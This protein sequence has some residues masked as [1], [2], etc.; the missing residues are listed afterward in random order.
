MRALRNG[1]DL[2]ALALLGLA[3][4]DLCER[5]LEAAG[6]S[7]TG[8]LLQRIAA[9]KS[10]IDDNPTL[11]PAPMRDSFN[12]QLVGV[13]SI[14]NALRDPNGRPR[15]DTPHREQVYVL[16]TAAIDY[17]AGLVDLALHF[18]ETPPE[19]VVR[20]TALRTGSPA[21]EAIPLRSS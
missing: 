1:S 15:A 3:I 2:A 6:G 14:L 11:V 4:E 17:A 8:T 19:V 18:S 20:Q 13:M 21:W 16:L 12:A 5:L 7:H 9:F 10:R